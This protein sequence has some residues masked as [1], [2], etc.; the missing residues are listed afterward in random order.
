MVQ[1][2]AFAALKPHHHSNDKPMF[3]GVP[4]RKRTHTFYALPATA[5]ENT[6]S[7]T[8]PASPLGVGVLSRPNT[9][10][11]LKSE[12]GK[13]PASHPTPTAPQPAPRRDP[14][15]PPHSHAANAKS[16]LA[17]APLHSSR[18]AATAATAL[19]AAAAA[20]TAR[21]ESIANFR[22]E[23]RKRLRRDPDASPPAVLNSSART[24]AV[25]AA[26]ALAASALAA[27]AARREDVASAREE[28][29]KRLGLA[30]DERERGAKCFPT[31]AEENSN[32]VEGR[33]AFCEGWDTLVWEQQQSYA[34]WRL[35][36]EACGGHQQGGGQQEQHGALV[37]S[38]GG[39]SVE[40]SATRAAAG[41]S[42]VPTG[43][44]MQTLQGR[45]LQR[46]RER[47]EKRERDRE[48]TEDGPN[49]QPQ[50]PT[51]GPGL[52]PASHFPVSLSGSLNRL[53]NSDEQARSSG[54]D[55]HGSLN[56][57]KGEWSVERAGLLQ[58][59][60][61]PGTLEWE[62]SQN[63]SLMSQ[64]ANQ[65]DLTLRQKQQLQQLKQQQQSLGFLSKMKQD[66]AR[67]IQNG[68]AATIAQLP[69][70]LDSLLGQHLSSAPVEQ[71]QTPKD[72]NTCPLPLQALLQRHIQQAIQKS[73]IKLPVSQQLGSIG[74]RGT[75]AS[76]P[77]ALLHGP[78]LPAAPVTVA[79]TISE[80]ALAMAKRREQ[81]GANGPVSQ[82]AAAIV[83]KGAKPGNS[84]MFMYG[85]HQLQ[86]HN[87][88]CAATATAAY[89]ASCAATAAAARAVADATALRDVKSQHVDVAP[90]GGDVSDVECVGD[91]PASS[92]QEQEGAHSRS[93][94]TSTHRD[95]SALT[96]LPQ[97]M[98]PSTA[99]AAPSSATAQPA[100]GPSLKTNHPASASTSNTLRPSPVAT[101]SSKAP[102]P[103]D[104]SVPQHTTPAAVPIVQPAK[105]QYIANMPLLAPP[106][107]PNNPGIPVFHRHPGNVTYNLD[108]GV[109]NLVPPPIQPLLASRT[110]TLPLPAAQNGRPAAANPSVPLPLP[111]PVILAPTHA[112][113]ASVRL[114]APLTALSQRTPSPSPA[115]TAAMLVTM[116]K[117]AR[118][119]PPVIAP[120]TNALPLPHPL[121]H[122]V[123]PPGMLV[124]TVYAPFMHSRLPSPVPAP[125]VP[126]PP[127]TYSQS[128]VAASDGRNTAH[129]IVPSTAKRTQPTAPPV[130]SQLSP[131]PFADDWTRLAQQAAKPGVATIPAS[132]A[133]AI[134]IAL[135]AAITAAK[136][137]GAS[138]A[139]SALTAGRTAAAAAAGLG[140]GNALAFDT[141]Q[142]HQ[143]QPDRRTSDQTV[144]RVFYYRQLAEGMDI[145]SLLPTKNGSI[146]TANHM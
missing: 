79:A 47:G 24:G 40:A 94:P 39:L 95:G 74:G 20:A 70:S 77:H 97:V 3:A 12:L 13:R 52:A 38:G 59:Q 51:W 46:E 123:E 99:T 37:S 139:A 91:F 83:S 11:V 4:R 122:R 10:T 115:A 32:R 67:N 41:K 132:T 53:S 73:P 27:A 117:A 21:L 106:F 104:S 29:R 118:P 119:P 31:L 36:C 121:M 65:E 42:S 75:T 143:K 114:P 107:V 71:Q 120:L 110:P 140:A 87:I 33:C 129:V 113:P 125:A 22:K 86:Q 88:A 98:I 30:V 44:V 102:A 146:Y 131:S 136:G 8:F 9:H 63:D 90:S 124:P 45:I 43:T 25:A 141:Q 85:Q 18:N 7:A 54:G 92:V 17:A 48:Q 128:P 126:P 16:Q 61:K 80:I 26:S 138:A 145:L 50:G 103:V 58:H 1:A 144:R 134:T 84:L 109:R 112:T 108:M 15:N 93:V 6:K 34:P 49:G 127:R 14:N 116:Q 100:T 60:H 5:A 62:C 35:M 55:W 133:A 142:P 137:G 2:S 76:D 64:L 101:I 82:Q 89:I 56:G 81:A 72:S 135:A 130:P 28:E 69:G 111:F 57:G 105:Q 96:S 19:A 68:V 23:E 66:I 78:S